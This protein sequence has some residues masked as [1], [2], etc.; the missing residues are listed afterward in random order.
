LQAF[1]DAE[2]IGLYHEKD[3]SISVAIRRRGDDVCELLAD[4]P[5]LQMLFESGSSNDEL[6]DKGLSC[7]RNHPGIA[8]LK[9]GQAIS[10]R[11]VSLFFQR[12][13]IFVN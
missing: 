11:P 3:S 8:T 9:L 7:L 2:D 12:F 1:A 13:R 5:R 4:I 10:A 6:T